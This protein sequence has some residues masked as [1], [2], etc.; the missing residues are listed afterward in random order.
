M[1]KAKSDK[2]ED[3]GEV[4][5]ENP[6]KPT[7]FSKKLKVAIFLKNWVES[8]PVSPNGLDKIFTTHRYGELVHDQSEIDRFVSIDAPVKVYVEHGSD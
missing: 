3:L 6:Q 5:A 8:R 1:V 4:F 2:T 7:E